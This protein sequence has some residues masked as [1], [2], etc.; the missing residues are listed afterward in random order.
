[1]NNLA[2]TLSYLGRYNEALNLEEQVLTANK[3]MFGDKHIDTMM[4]MNNLALTLNSLGR[5]DEAL[6]LQQQVLSLN[7]EYLETSIQIPL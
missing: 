7:K 4:A 5:Y 6:N 1:M 3:E 2:T